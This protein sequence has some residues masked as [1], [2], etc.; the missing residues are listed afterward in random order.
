MC[1]T[2]NDKR[3]S[4]LFKDYRETTRPLLKN[5][6]KRYG[7]IPVNCLNEIRAMNDHL[8]KYCVEGLTEQVAEKEL[9]GMRS[10]AK[11]LIYDCFKQLDMFFSD[12]AIE[13]EKKYYNQSWL[14]IDGGKFWREYRKNKKMAE[15]EIIEAKKQESYQPEVAKMH[16]DKALSHYNKIESLFTTYNDQLVEGK[17]KR[18]WERLTGYLKDYVTEILLAVGV[19]ILT[20]TIKAFLS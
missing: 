6:K 18:G 19:A 7:S 8:S 17:D 2:E 4:E 12:N 16:F 9:G 15:A 3:L 14:H 1:M 11:R 20:V 13:W 5:L 10:H